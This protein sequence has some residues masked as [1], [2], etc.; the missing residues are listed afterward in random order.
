MA[1]AQAQPQPQPNTRLAE[2]SNTSQKKNA[3]EAVKAIYKMISKYNGI[4]RRM[5]ETTEPV[6]G[7]WS[8]RK[9]VDQSTISYYAQ[10]LKG[11]LEP[12][13]H[14]MFQLS[15]V[16]EPVLS[17][18]V[19]MIDNMIKMIDMAPPFTMVDSSAYKQGTFDYTGLND[20]M[21][22]GSI[23]DYINLLQLR[24]NTLKNTRDN[25]DTSKSGYLKSL[26]EN[27]RADVKQTIDKTFKEADL[28][29]EKTATEIIKAKQMMKSKLK[30]FEINQDVLDALEL[31][32][33][34]IE[35]LN[36]PVGDIEDMDT[37]EVDQF[38]S[39][40]SSAT[41]IF[42]KQD[43]KDKSEI[44]E[45]LKDLKKQMKRITDIFEK[46]NN[47]AFD[48]IELKNRNP[49]MADEYTVYANRASR[50][51]R[52]ILKGDVPTG[53]RIVTIGKKKVGTAAGTCGAGSGPYVYYE[54]KG[55]Q[56]NTMGRPISN[57]EKINNDMINANRNWQINNNGP[58]DTPLGNLNPFLAQDN[59]SKYTYEVLL[60]KQNSEIHPEVNA[61]GANISLLQGPITNMS[62]SGKKSK[63]MDKISKVAI[64]EKNDMFKPMEVG[65]KGYIPEEKED[66]FKL[67]DL[68]P[69]K[70]K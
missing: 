12:L 34:D 55:T 30:S 3:D 54:P 26:P 51:E 59:A 39:G 33:E 10:V 35:D 14:L 5:I 69:K 58:H 63:A 11:L 2:E 38:Y 20:D 60:A 8:T 44:K 56:Y 27:R 1:E 31:S 19:N 17:S 42:E 29:M 28:A 4:V 48:I 23:K 37:T 66:Q 64:D 41:K 7:P 52:D 24:M 21:T 68:K 15:K 40:V 65:D 25:F 45:E 43:A 57:D 47:M 6:K 53:E 61:L 70:R 9:S 67:P 32:K 49:S 18:M 50:L 46:E 22:V 16:N 62:G 36:L 13:K